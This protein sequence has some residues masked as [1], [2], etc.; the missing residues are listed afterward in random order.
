[1]LHNQEFA[2]H[3]LD[4]AQ[5]SEAGT[6]CNKLSPVITFLLSSFIYP[7]PTPSSTE[8][9]PLPPSIAVPERIFCA[10][11][12]TTRL[13]SSVLSSCR[14]LLLLF[15]LLPACLPGNTIF[16]NRL[17]FTLYQ[18][19]KRGGG[20]GGGDSSRVLGKYKYKF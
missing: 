12:F 6:Y 15:L 19:H 1:M 13:K 17:S 5:H 3:R 10:N 16:L 4:P 18:Q 2:L 8:R 9:F 11:K 20:G 7:Q 14:L